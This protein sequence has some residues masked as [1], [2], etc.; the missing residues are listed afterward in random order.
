MTGQI[1]KF[2]GVFFL[3]LFC[4]ILISMIADILPAFHFSGIFSGETHFVIKLLIF[5]PFSLAVSLLLMKLFLMQ[6]KEHPTGLFVSLILL[7]LFAMFLWEFR[8]HTQDTVTGFENITTS[9]DAVQTP[10]QPEMSKIIRL[11]KKINKTLDVI[12]YTGNFND[13]LKVL[14]ENTSE[15]PAETGE[16]T[17]ATP[18]ENVLIAE[19]KAVILGKI[20]QEEQHIEIAKKHDP[21]FMRGYNYLMEKKYFYAER[22]FRYNL[23]PANRYFLNKSL[24]LL[25]RQGQQT[26]EENHQNIRRKNQLVE[27]GVIVEK[28][29]PS[30][31]R[32]V[33]EFYN[34]MYVIFGEAGLTNALSRYAQLISIDEITDREIEMLQTKNKKSN[35]IYQTRVVLQDKSG[36]KKTMLENALLFIKRAYFIEGSQTVYFKGVSLYTGQSESYDIEITRIDKNKGIFRSFTGSRQ[37]VYHHGMITLGDYAVNIIHF[38]SVYPFGKN[39][40]VFYL[41]K[42]EKDSLFYKLL[43]PMLKE[44]MK[45][46]SGILFIFALTLWLA[47]ILQ[48][49]NKKPA[50]KLLWILPV[51]LLPVFSFFVV[52]FAFFITGKLAEWLT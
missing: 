32:T 1:F 39:L 16:P 27:A 17:T 52:H 29:Y 5:I 40:S 3:V 19:L 22:Y 37:G 18:P 4:F 46:Y 35:L 45:Y 33:Y 47:Y 11:R 31:P 7:L 50:N 42:L 28:K 10:V 49:K 51:I 30:D 26:L 14:S 38:Q 20:K 2:L 13:A 34:D 15:Q 23:M 48:G 41:M 12:Y 43:R 9:Q 6:E 21:D 24:A 8:S 44:K 36:A 25:Q